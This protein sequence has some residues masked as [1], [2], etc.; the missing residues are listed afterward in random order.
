MD[1]VPD[2]A[3]DYAGSFVDWSGSDGIVIYDPPVRSP[4]KVG[5]RVFD[6]NGTPTSPHEFSRP[7]PYVGGPKP[8][9]GW[10]NFGDAPTAPY[11]SNFDSRGPRSHYVPAPRAAAGYDPTDVSRACDRCS[12]AA[13]RYGSPPWCARCAGTPPPPE[14]F[15]PRR[16]HL[17]GGREWEGGQAWADRA[18]VYG[19]S[20]DPRPHPWPV[21][22]EK[23]REPCSTYSGEAGCGD[24]ALHADHFD[25]N[26]SHDSHRSGLASQVATL[27]VILMVMVFVIL[28]L[29]AIMLASRSP[30]PT[31]TFLVSLAGPNSGSPSGSPS[32]P[33][34]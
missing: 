18:A 27:K 22:Y 9:P 29:G 34:P 2:Y 17:S 7:P 25:N 30:T 32:G 19:V 12:A 1:A 11:T 28:V 16:E 21:G 13:T 20:W 26:D 4:G 31:P 5:G 6:R 33:Q 15:S 10:A 24:A 23:R 8:A 3:F 14:Y